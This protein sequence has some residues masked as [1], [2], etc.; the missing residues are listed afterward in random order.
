MSLGRSVPAKITV[1]CELG[2][3]WFNIFVADALI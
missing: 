1:I 3:L 2:S